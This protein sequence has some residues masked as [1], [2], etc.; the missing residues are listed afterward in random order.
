MGGTYASSGEGIHY[1]TLSSTTY[2]NSSWDSGSVYAYNRWHP[3]W[4]GFADQ[5][6]PGDDGDGPAGDH[7]HA[8]LDQR[9]RERVAIPR[10]R[11]RL[12][13]D[14]A[15]GHGGERGFGTANQLGAYAA[16]GVH[17]G[18]DNRGYDVAGGLASALGGQDVHGL[19][20]TGAEEQ[21]IALRRHDRHDDYDGTLPGVDGRQ[22]SRLAVAPLD[23]RVRAG[24]PEHRQQRGDFR[25]GDGQRDA[26]RHARGR[27]GAAEQQRRPN[28]AQS[29]R[30]AAGPT[31]GPSSRP[32]MRRALATVTGP[33]AE[34][35]AAEAAGTTADRAMISMGPW[36]GTR[37]P[38][39]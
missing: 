36:M 32:T 18:S 5:R 6:N 30:G 13:R 14:P 19:E 24:Q 4:I 39:F 12:R 27:A 15:D 26:R 17:N 37:S 38:S 2:D 8:D 10:A 1:G 29:D 11:W 21:A 7:D 3:F 23:G 20:F 33:M 25:R 16:G 31:R 34:M 28:R 9:Q 22:P 35:P